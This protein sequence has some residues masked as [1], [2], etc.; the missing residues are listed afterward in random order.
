MGETL[1]LQGVDSILT[2]K[3]IGRKTR[4]P[5][6]IAQIRT[7]LTCFAF[8][9]TRQTPSSPARSRSISESPAQGTVQRNR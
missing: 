1:F 2:Q 3:A 5:F 6:H 4:L 7:F 8:F 9:S